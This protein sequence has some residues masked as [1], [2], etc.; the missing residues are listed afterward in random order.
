MKFLDVVYHHRLFFCGNVVQFDDLFDH[1]VRI[2]SL[3]LQCQPAVFDLANQKD[4]FGERLQVVGAA[5]DGLPAGLRIAGIRALVQQFCVPVEDE[6]LVAQFMKQQVV[7]FNRPVLLVVQRLDP[8]FQ[9][10]RLAPAPDQVACLQQNFAYRIGFGQKRIGTELE[11]AILV[12]RRVQCREHD[13]RNAGNAG[14]GMLPKQ[15]AD[16]PAVQVR[17]HDVEQHQVRVVAA[18]RSAGAQ[19]IFSPQNHVTRFV[20]RV[21]ERFEDLG[22]VFDNQ[23]PGGNAWCRHRIQLLRFGFFRMA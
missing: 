21:G 12:V 13:N 20:Q 11:T 3:G 22:F 14:V 16:L 19:A 10:N 2:E 18:D 4:F 1:L 17:Q 23:N 7:Q 9:V 6:K 15:F 8:V 5:V